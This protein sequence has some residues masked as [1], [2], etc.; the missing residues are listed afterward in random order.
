MHRG[1]SYEPWPTLYKH[2]KIKA[3]HPVAYK[4]DMAMQPCSSLPL[5][6]TAKTEVRGFWGLLRH[7]M[8]TLKFRKHAQVL[9]WQHLQARFATL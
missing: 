9:C 3:A 5:T 1:L 2:Q 7:V 8:G 6:K 4:I